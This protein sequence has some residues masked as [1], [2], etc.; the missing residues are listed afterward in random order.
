MCECSDCVLRLIKDKTLKCEGN[1]CSEECIDNLKKAILLQFDSEDD[2]EL[3]TNINATKQTVQSGDSDKR[4]VIATNMYEDP[5]Y[6]GQIIDIFEDFLTKRS[7]NIDNIEK[8]DQDPNECAIIYGTDYGELQTAL[9][10]L[11]KN[12]RIFALKEK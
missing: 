4:L 10:S 12:W 7:I 11:M 6:I 3:M 9:E 5:E 2:E 8:E 1:P